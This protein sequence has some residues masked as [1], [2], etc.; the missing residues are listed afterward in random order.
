MKA[1]KRKKLI[2]ILIVLAVIIAAV[3]AYVI[4]KP[5]F[6]IGI[7]GDGLMPAPQ[8]NEE[9]LSYSNRVGSEL[10]RLLD[11]LERLSLDKEFV[12]S[13]AFTNLNDFSQDLE[14]QPADRANP[15][16]PVQ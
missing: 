9:E 15:F 3:V 7:V 8:S 14:D 16:A 10:I 12:Q 11:E 4:F 2:T 5:N 6:N 13:E 1:E